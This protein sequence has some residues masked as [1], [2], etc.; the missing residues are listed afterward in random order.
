MPLDEDIT[1]TLQEKRLFANVKTTDC[2]GSLRVLKLGSQFDIATVLG[3]VVTT[4]R[5]YC[6]GSS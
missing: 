6:D 4:I 1:L 5:E 3:K 2:D